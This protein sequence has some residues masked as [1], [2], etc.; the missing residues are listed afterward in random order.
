MAGAWA[1]TAPSHPLL[2]AFFVNT[3]YPMIT[4]DE[5]KRQANLAKHGLDLADAALVYDAPQQG[6][7]R[8]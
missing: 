2:L 6:H 7:T 1:I 3:I 8:R 5:A 4:Y